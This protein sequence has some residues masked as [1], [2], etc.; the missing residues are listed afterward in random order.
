MSG[1]VM[2]MTAEEA[3]AWERHKGLIERAQEIRDRLNGCRS[4]RE[5]DQVVK[6]VGPEVLGWEGDGDVLRIHIVNL[7]K[8]RRLCIRKGWG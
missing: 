8:Y 4:V 6:E 2:E 3:A 5:V 7:A 1:W